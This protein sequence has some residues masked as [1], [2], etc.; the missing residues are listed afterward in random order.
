MTRI[1][2]HDEYGDL[3]DVIETY[4]NLPKAK[5]IDIV[6]DSMNSFEGWEGWFEGMTKTKLNKLSRGVLLANA[7]HLEYRPIKDQN[8]VLRDNKIRRP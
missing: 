3:L 1:Y 4:G 7:V 6:F 5:L 2:E 8:N